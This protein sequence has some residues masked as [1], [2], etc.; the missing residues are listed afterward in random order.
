MYGHVVLKLE[1]AGNRKYVSLY[2]RGRKIRPRSRIRVGILEDGT[3]TIGTVKRVRRSLEHAPVFYSPKRPSDGYAVYFVAES[4][5][6]V[7]KAIKEAVERGSSILRVKT[8]LLRVSWE[9]RRLSVELWR[10]RVRNKTNVYF[11]GYNVDILIPDSGIAVEVDGLYHYQ[12]RVQ[13]K[14]V[15]KLELLKRAGLD[16][17]RID[18]SEIRKDPGAV[19]EMLKTA[20]LRRLEERARVKSR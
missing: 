12:E 20:H 5:E 11:R 1:V 13:K 15:A 6:D 14:D 16:V 9:E 4:D 10:R 17:F 18:A 2:Y 3:V 7:R 8:K 19:A